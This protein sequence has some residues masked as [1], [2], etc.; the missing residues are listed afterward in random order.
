MTFTGVPSPDL[1]ET[2]ES[3]ALAGG[4][5]RVAVVYKL[6]RGVHNPREETGADLADFR[7]ACRVN[8]RSDVRVD[9]VARGTIIEGLQYP[10]EIE[11]NTDR[12]NYLLGR[13]G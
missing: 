4:L 11:E 13:T 1:D 12:A 10:L 5:A 8:A 9:I 7:K 6:R 3:T 2:G